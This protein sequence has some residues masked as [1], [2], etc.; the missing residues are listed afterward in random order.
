MRAIRLLRVALLLTSLAL[1]QHLSA[2][3]PAPDLGDL[4]LDTTH[5]NWPAPESL[6]ADLRSSDDQRRL[7]ALLL[8]G[9]SMDQ[10]KIQEWDQKTGKPRE[11]MQVTPLQAVQLTYAAIGTDDTQYA[12]LSIESGQMDFAAIAAP[13]GQ[14]WTRIATVQCWCKYDQHEPN[15]LLSQFIQLHVF[16]DGSYEPAHYEL[17]VRASGGGTGIY[18]QY[19]AR[20]RVQGDQL[21]L[22]LHFI[23]GYRSCPEAP[24]R[25]C[26]VEKR[27]ILP[28]SVDRGPGVVLVESRQTFPLDRIRPLDVRAFIPELSPQPARGLTCVSYKWDVPTFSYQRIPGI[29]EMCRPTSLERKHRGQPATR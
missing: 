22:I 20:F 10:A 2:Q 15:A 28:Q 26:T 16:P 8:L 24:A 17:G 19:E 14:G 29:P 23:S 3:L 4:D 12:I 18:T 11:Q 25:P 21:R 9:L 6:V 5:L 13:S 1:V 27:W 7:Q